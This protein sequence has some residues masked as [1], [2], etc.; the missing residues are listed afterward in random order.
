MHVVFPS[1]EWQLEGVLTAASPS[2]GAAVICHPHPLYGG[3]M[4]NPVVRALEEGL[5]RGGY[6]TLRFNFRG[7][8]ESTGT[9][10]GGVGE[11]KDL[12]AAV[13]CLL[14]RTGA[15]EVV[16]AGYSFGAMV[17]LQAGPSIPTTSRLIAVAPPLSFFSLAGLS[18]GAIPK[19]FIV[20]DQDQ[21]CSATELIEQ[22]SHV[23]E[24]KKSVVLGGADHFLFGQEPAI[25]DAV[26]E[27]VATDGRG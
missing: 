13:G 26:A 18:L 6:S 10:A 15:S 12:H 9:Y 23:P 1:D 3:N 19:L 17:A 7:T 24:P 4:N 21:H 2:R 11:G 25:R 20:G 14:E 8:G 5:Q 16:V 27:F 22:L